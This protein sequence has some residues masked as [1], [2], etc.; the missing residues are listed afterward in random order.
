MTGA[1]INGIKDEVI[2][3]GF[4]ELMKVDIT[5]LFS[6]IDDYVMQVDEREDNGWIIEI[7]DMLIREQADEKLINVL[8]GGIAHELAHIVRKQR[9]LFNI[10]MDKFLYKISKRYVELDERNTDLIV[11]LRGYGEELLKFLEYSEK[12]YSRYEEDGLS[13]IELKTLLGYWLNKKEKRK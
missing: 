7:D 11:F 12:K 10:W 6:K 5:A 2:K 13:Q 3:N 1:E 4:P 9:G 8:K